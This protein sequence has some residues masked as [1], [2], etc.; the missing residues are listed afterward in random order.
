MLPGNREGED[1]R[2]R[3][4]ACATHTLLSHPPP[5]SY[6]QCA[7]LGK[8]KGENCPELR[9]EVSFCS[10]G[11]ATL[12]CPPLSGLFLGRPF[13]S[14]LSKMHVPIPLKTL[15]S[16]P[17][18]AG[19][20]PGVTFKRMET[21]YHANWPCGIALAFHKSSCHSSFFLTLFLM[22]G[23][24]LEIRGFPYSQKLNL[25]PLLTLTGRE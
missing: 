11:N 22:I 13:S 17:S 7:H 8:G 23:L 16:P 15:Y 19:A 12:T 14:L 4:Q 3:H 9:W 2:G 21:K 24:L 10:C 20:W 6:S 1:G 25:K 5:C 18:S